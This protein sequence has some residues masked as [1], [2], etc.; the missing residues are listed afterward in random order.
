MGNDNEAVKTDREVDAKEDWW[1]GDVA[2]VVSITST[3][4]GLNAY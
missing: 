4:G 3:V 2:L 1:H